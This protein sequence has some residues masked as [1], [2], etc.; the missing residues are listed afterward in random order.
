MRDVVTHK[1]TQ[2]HTHAHC[3]RTTDGAVCKLY[4]TNNNNNQAC[5]SST[6]THNTHTDIR[7]H[8]QF[9]VIGDIWA[10]FI[11][12]LDADTK[13]KTQILL[14]AIVTTQNKIFSEIQ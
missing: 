9:S 8:E 12:N 3:N 13:H 4:C 11:C 2:A 14:F 10:A 5:H 6:Q 1:H 7:A